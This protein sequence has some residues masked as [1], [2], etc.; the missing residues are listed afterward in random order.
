MEDGPLAVSG[1]RGFLYISVR[2]QQNRLLLKGKNKKQET[3]QNKTFYPHMAER[4]GDEFDW[5][6]EK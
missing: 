4:G 3:K 5:L 2:L 6:I 1:M